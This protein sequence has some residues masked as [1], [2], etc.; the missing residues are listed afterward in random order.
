MNNLR[1]LS[2]RS[3][4][5]L[6]AVIGAFILSAFTVERIENNVKEKQQTES[7]TLLKDKIL[8]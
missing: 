5:I 3:W 8:D 7:T 4:L 2:S 6:V 1:N